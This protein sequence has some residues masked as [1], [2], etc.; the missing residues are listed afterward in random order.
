MINIAKIIINIIK[1]IIFI[2]LQKEDI[3]YNLQ[4]TNIDEL[5]YYNELFIIIINNFLI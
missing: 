4:I 5:H 1:L 2:Y 3:D